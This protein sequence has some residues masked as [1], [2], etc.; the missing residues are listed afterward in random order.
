MDNFID[1]AYEK[2]ELDKKAYNKY[3]N[4]CFIDS[5]TDEGYACVMVDAPLTFNS[6]YGTPLHKKYL[7]IILRK[8][9]LEQLK[10]SDL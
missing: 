4:S 8:M 2:L 5:E 7:T 10:K 9:K 1:K 6:W 3:Y